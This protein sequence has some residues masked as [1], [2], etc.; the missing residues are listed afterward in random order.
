[1]NGK[2]KEKI[3]ENMIYFVFWMIGRGMYCI[4]TSD[5]HVASVVATVRL[6]DHHVVYHI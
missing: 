6:L 1:M 5:M 4:L 3:R 2:I